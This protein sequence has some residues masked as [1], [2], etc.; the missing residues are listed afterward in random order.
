MRNPALPGRF[1]I[2]P[3]RSFPGVLKTL[4]HICQ[5]NWQEMLIK[6][7]DNWMCCLISPK[8]SLQAACRRAPQPVRRL[9]LLTVRAAG[10]GAQGEERVAVTRHSCSFTARYISERN[11]MPEYSKTEPARGCLK[12]TRLRFPQK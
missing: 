8:P 1:G 2:G 5:G 7:W 12:K 4:M 9:R 10:I 3:A 11:C 6:T